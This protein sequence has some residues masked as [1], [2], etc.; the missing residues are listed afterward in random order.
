M[1]GTATPKRS[2]VLIGLAVMGL[3]IALLFVFWRL[4]SVVFAGVTAMHPTDRLGVCIIAAAI[5][6]AQFSRR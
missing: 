1:S 3:I 4:G 6:H 2:N 5:L